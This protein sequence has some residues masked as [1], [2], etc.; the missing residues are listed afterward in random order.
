VGTIAVALLAGALA[1]IALRL[2]LVVPTSSRIRAALEPHQRAFAT[3]RQLPVRRSLLQRLFE[4]TEAAFSGKTAWRALERRLDRSGVKLDA[5]RFLYLSLGLSLLLGFLAA[6]AGVSVAV[7]ILLM[8]IALGLP[9]LGIS[10]AAGR[11][12]RSVEDQLPET[13]D[14]LAGLLKGGQSLQQ[15]LQTVASDGRPPIS[16]EVAYALREIELGLSVNDALANMAA[17]IRSRDLDFVVT[18]IAI[19]NQIG[20][21]LAGLFEQVSETV[22]ER[23]LFARRVQSLTASGRLTAYVLFAMPFFAAGILSLG[24]HGYLRPLFHTAAGAVMLSIA[25]VLMAVGSL[26]LRR[27]VAFKT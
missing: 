12:M 13:L 21:S 3:T 22:R 9:Y 11:R 23:H 17:R 1:A 20:G 8:L 18:A 5:A 6:L 19:Q 26:L 27:I 25:L 24:N 15:A 10:F 7:T 16:T 4:A 2:V 14:S